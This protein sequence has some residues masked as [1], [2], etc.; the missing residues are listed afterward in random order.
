MKIDFISMIL[1]TIGLI[2]FTYAS[3]RASF[4]DHALYVFDIHYSPNNWMRDG[5]T[6]DKVRDEILV[7][8][9]KLRKN[10][11][12]KDLIE[13]GETSEVDLQTLYDTMIREHGRQS[14]KRVV[15]LSSVSTLL[16]GI[17]LGRLSAKRNIQQVATGHG[18]SHHP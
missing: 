14:R 12:L 11:D 3:L 18:V 15:F 16:L 6:H 4:D 10:E 1:A 7:F 2:G 13:S 5:L 17:G 8:Q 9:P